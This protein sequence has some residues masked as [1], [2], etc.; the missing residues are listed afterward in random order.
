MNLST[1]WLILTARKRLF[2]AVLGGVVLIVLAVCLIM[3]ETYISGTSLVIDTKTTD[4]VTGTPGPP[5]DVSATVLATQL[6]IIL[7][8]NVALKVV[9]KLNLTSDAYF[10]KKFG[11]GSAGK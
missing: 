11:D 1:I 2:F 10:I 5:G 8:H 3:P 9:D 6:D 4:P 7:S